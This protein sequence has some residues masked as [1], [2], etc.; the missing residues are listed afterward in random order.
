MS[1]LCLSLHPSCSTNTHLHSYLSLHTQLLPQ[2][3]TE[4]SAG[5][6][7]SFALSLLGSL[8]ALPALPGLEQ[9]VQ[10]QQ[11]SICLCL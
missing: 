3:G 2:A 9:A 1:L 6:G 11:V 10:A 4:E 8:D 5:G 7:A